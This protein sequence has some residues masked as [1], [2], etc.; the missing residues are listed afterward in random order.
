MKTTDRFEIEQQSRE[1]Q[2]EETK[3]QA[4][5]PSPPNMVSKVLSLRSLCVR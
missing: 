3:F 2:K 4:G 5:A 1:V